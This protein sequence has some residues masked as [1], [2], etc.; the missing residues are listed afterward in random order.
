[1]GTTMYFIGVPFL[2]NRKSSFLLGVGGDATVV[3]GTI[4]AR[5]AEA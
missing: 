5:V 2:R 3:P 4:A 1:M